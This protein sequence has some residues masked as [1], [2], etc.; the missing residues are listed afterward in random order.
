[1]LATMATALTSGLLV[2]QASALACLVS[3]IAVQT[4]GN[5]PI[6]REQVRQFYL[7]NSESGM[8]DAV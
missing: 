6:G 3:A 7:Q 4:V 5:Q 2:M 1:L 8:I